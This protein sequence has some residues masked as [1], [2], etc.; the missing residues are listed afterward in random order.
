MDEEGD[1][2]GGRVAAEG[3]EVGANAASEEVGASVAPSEGLAGGEG[4]GEVELG[5]AD[6]EGLPCA[7]LGWVGWF[8]GEEALLGSAWPGS[9]AARFGEGRGSRGRR[10]R[11]LHRHR[12][13]RGGV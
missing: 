1:G 8:G 2:G 13:R 5:A 9:G 10:S 4:E 11:P 6:L 7:G 12:R 3:D